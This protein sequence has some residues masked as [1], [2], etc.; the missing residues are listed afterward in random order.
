VRWATL[1]LSSDSAKKSVSPPVSLI[2]LSFLQKLVVSLFLARGHDSVSFS[3]RA[4]AQRPTLFPF[5][6]FLGPSFPST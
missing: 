2:F 1:T 3:P 4:R 6:F 5:D